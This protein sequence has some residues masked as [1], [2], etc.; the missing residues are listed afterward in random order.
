[1]K[2]RRHFD[3]AVYS[4]RHLIAPRNLPFQYH[5]R[6]QE[7]IEWG[8][9]P[10]FYVSRSL[11]KTRKRVLKTLHSSNKHGRN[12]PSGAHPNHNG[13][14]LSLVSRVFYTRH[15]KHPSCSYRHVGIVILVIQIHHLRDAGLDDHLAA[16]VARKERHV[17]LRI[18]LDTHNRL[19]T[20][21]ICRVDVQNRIHLRVAHVHV[22]RVQLTASLAAPRQHVIT[23]APRKAVVSDSNDLIEGI[24]DAAHH[25][26]SPFLPCAN[27]RVRVLAAHGAETRQAHKVLIPADVVIP[28][29][30]HHKMEAQQ[31]SSLG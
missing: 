24:H 18:T 23:A 15:I 31:P 2:N 28:L 30:F 19:A 10:G 1:M 16:V 7:A 27:L 20:T 17:Q 9:F 5:K 22:L 25:A 13:L 11:L 26:T 3:F 21:R 14:P 29:L 6:V 12:T 8:L 4:T